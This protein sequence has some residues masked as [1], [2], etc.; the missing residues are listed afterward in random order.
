M[1]TGNRILFVCNILFLIALVAVIVFQGLPLNASPGW[2]YK[3]VVANLLT[4]VT[5]VLAFIGLAVALAAIWGWQTISQG[6]AA[7]AMQAA[8]SKVDTYIESDVFKERLA[9]SLREQYEN[10]EKTKAQ[11][12]VVAEEQNDGPQVAVGAGDEAWT[13]DDNG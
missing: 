1:S 10:M 9:I 4:V 2:E 7:K 12:A 6:A 11:D 5:I 8:Q 13:D 3:D